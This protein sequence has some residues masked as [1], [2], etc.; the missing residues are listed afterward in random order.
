MSP[1]LLLYSFVKIV[2][3]YKLSGVTFIIMIGR[4]RHHHDQA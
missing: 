1:D 3:I 2:M 4:D